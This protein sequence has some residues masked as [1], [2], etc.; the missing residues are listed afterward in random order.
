MKFVCQLRGGYMLATQGWEKYKVIYTGYPYPDTYL[1]SQEMLTMMLKK[2]NI[3]D[4]AKITTIAELAD[5]LASYVKE[6]PV[7]SYKS[8]RTFLKTGVADT[9][10]DMGILTF[11]ECKYFSVYFVDDVESSEGYALLRNKFRE[12][13]DLNVSYKK[14]FILHWHLTN[15]KIVVKGSTPQADNLEYGNFKHLIVEQLKINV[16]D[17]KKVLNTIYD[18]EGKIGLPI[19]GKWGT[20]EESFECYPLSEHTNSSFIGQTYRITGDIRTTFDF[21]NRYRSVSS[22]DNAIVR[23]LVELYGYDVFYMAA[24]RRKFKEDFL[25]GLYACYFDI[26][27]ESKKTSVEEKVR[28]LVRSLIIALDTIG[29]EMFYGIENGEVILLLSP[30][31]Y[32]M[33][34]VGYVSDIMLF[35]LDSPKSLRVMPNGRQMLAVNLSYC[36]EGLLNDME[37]KWFQYL[38]LRRISLI[39]A[40]EVQYC[41]LS[42]ETWFWGSDYTVSNRYSTTNVLNVL[43]PNFSRLY[44]MGGFKE[45]NVD[46][47]ARTVY[48]LGTATFYGAGEYLPALDQALSGE[49]YTEDERALFLTLPSIFKYNMLGR[50]TCQ[51]SIFNQEES[52]IVSPELS[53]ELLRKLSY[54]LKVYLLVNAAWVRNNIEDLLANYKYV[55]KYE[56]YKLTI[57]FVEDSL[58]P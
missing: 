46:K 38:L 24:A 29:S 5:A 58:R 2:L 53:D 10:R 30:Y 21:W 18:N 28:N 51:I 14:A 44:L 19:K 22:G 37:S 41:D 36:A 43:V 34:T 45:Q 4:E 32:A 35:D 3:E 56:D 16:S 57:K 11:F 12:D 27:D 13:S 33:D 1:S 17:L 6:Q 42:S 8:M 7:F 39:V 9:K 20:L 25:L 52:L 15:H 54:I 47:I 50:Y 40:D 55:F 31:I 48:E 23:T 26:V 49:Q